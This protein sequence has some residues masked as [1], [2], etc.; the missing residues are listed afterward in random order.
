MAS[1]NLQRKYNMTD[2]DLCELVSFLCRD[3]LKNLSD[4]EP[5]GITV[6]S[7]SHLESLVA[8]FIDI[9]PDEY[10]LL[11]V[12]EATESKNNIRESLLNIIRSMNLRVEMKWGRNSSQNQRLISSSVLNLADAELLQVAIYVHS[13][14]T[15][16][17]PWLVEQG[18]TQIMLDEFAKLNENFAMAMNKKADKI[19][20]RVNKT[21]ERITKGNEMFDLAATYCNIGKRIYSNKDHSLYKYFLIYKGAKDSYVKIPENVIFDSSNRLIKWDATPKATSYQVAAKLNNPKSNWKTIY[22]G[23]SNFAEFKTAPDGWIIKIRARN[24]RGYGDWCKEIS[25]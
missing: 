12:M 9:F 24:S 8:A 15:E 10:Y 20:D 2:N 25:L 22:K 3:I 6:G 19:T 7:I 18:L 5:Y 16:Y 17:L 4:F 23:E 13:K 11:D 1:N 21:T 14:M